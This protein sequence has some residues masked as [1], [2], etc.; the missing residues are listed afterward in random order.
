M[1]S[2]QNE[3]MMPRDANEIYRQILKRKLD[4]AVTHAMP[5]AMAGD[6]DGAEQRIRTVD[7]DVYGWLACSLRL[8]PCRCACQS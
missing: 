4:A 7:C 3:R 2:N 1:Y 5:L 8:A 6:F